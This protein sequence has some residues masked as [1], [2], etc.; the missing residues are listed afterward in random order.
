[1][2]KDSLVVASKVKA[3]IKANGMMA[4]SEIIGALS[5]CVYA[6]LDKA[7][8]RCKANGRKTVRAQDL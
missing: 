3:H 8:V 4:S 2:A 7:I 1:M 5:D 6:C